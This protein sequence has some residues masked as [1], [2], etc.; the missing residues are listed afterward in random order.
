MAAIDVGS[1]AIDRNSQANNITLIGKDNPANL[2]GKI[3]QVETY[4]KT[5]G[6][7]WTVRVGTC[8]KVDT[9]DFTTR[10]FVDIQVS[11]GHNAVAVDLDIEAG[12]YIFYQRG[13]PEIDF[14]TSGGQGMWYKAVDAPFASET[15]SFEASDIVSLYG[16]GEE[17][18][19][20][21][22]KGYPPAFSLAVT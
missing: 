5:A 16:T 12:D 17:P 3:T 8:Y 13:V 11:A 18:A 14:G 19:A 22:M 20:G 10:D 15:F 6:G 9:N 2:S 1:A 4:I 7:P 21:G